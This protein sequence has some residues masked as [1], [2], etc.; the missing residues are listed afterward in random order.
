VDRTERTLEGSYY[1]SRE[2]MNI[3]FATSKDLEAL[4]WDGE[5]AHFRRLFERAIEEAQ[6]GRR[7]LLLAEIEGQLV[8]QLFVQLTTRANFSTEG[9]SSGYLYAFRVKPPYRNQ[10][11]GSQLIHEA[12]SNLADRGFLR[13]VI[14]V[15]KRNVAARR[16]YERAGYAVFTEDAGNWSYI[17]HEGRLREVREPAFVLE[18][19]L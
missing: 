17:D 1:D 10:G 9:V 8:G 5:Y 11:V 7:I 2:P 19:W 3:R 13:T 14:S 15:A 6:H 12:E 18:K 4:E 16:L